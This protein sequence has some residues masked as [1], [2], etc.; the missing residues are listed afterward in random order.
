MIALTCRCIN[1]KNFSML[2]FFHLYFVLIVSGECHSK[3]QLN[4][5]DLRNKVIVN[6]LYVSLS[7]PT[8][9]LNGIIFYCLN[10]GPNHLWSAGVYCVHITDAYFLVFVNFFPVFLIFNLYFFGSFSLK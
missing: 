10:N 5:F 4:V 1:Q 8:D 2:L 7:P 9:W 3:V 6:F